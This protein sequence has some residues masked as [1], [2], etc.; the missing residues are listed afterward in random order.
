MDGDT[1]RSAHRRWSGAPPGTSAWH[2]LLWVLVIGAWPLLGAMNTSL[3]VAVFQ[4]SILWRL[5]FSLS[6]LGLS[7]PIIRWMSQHVPSP[8]PRMSV[9][10]AALSVV[11]SLMGGPVLH[12]AV[13][14]MVRGSAVAPLS[15]V[16]T[17]APAWLSVTD[18]TI[19]LE[20]QT[21]VSWDVY[22]RHATHGNRSTTEYMTLAPV[23]SSA[24]DRG[25]ARVW[26]CAANSLEMTQATPTGAS[27]P[28]SG[29]SGAA[30]LDALGDAVGEDPLCITAH[31]ASRAELRRRAA[32]VWGVYLSA[33]LALLVFL[34]RSRQ[35]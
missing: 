18:G 15:E 30:Y 17:P 21:R 32:I 22:N 5:F 12:G 25:P 2:T 34:L 3:T 35:R 19:S 23:R 4:G 6:T 31:S 13:D 7:L 26:V 8:R 10:L 11:W 27:R 20:E 33:L 28:W 24:T 9:V 1:P 14:L 29:A 16:P